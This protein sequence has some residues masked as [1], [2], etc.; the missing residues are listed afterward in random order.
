MWFASAEATT[1]RV[2][3][4][5][6]V[7]W[8]TAACACCSARVTPA[9]VPA[10][11]ASASAN[12]SVGASLMP[13]SVFW[14]W[15]LSRKVMSFWLGNVEMFAKKIDCKYSIPLSV[16]GTSVDPFWLARSHE[17]GTVCARVAVELLTRCDQVLAQWM[18]ETAFL[19]H[20]IFFWSF[21]FY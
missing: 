9:T 17:G 13:I 12:L 20:C 6:R 16:C 8:P 15:S 21:F 19:S 5:S 2:F 3:P 18:V 14:T 7:S 10:G 1:S 11:L 4:W